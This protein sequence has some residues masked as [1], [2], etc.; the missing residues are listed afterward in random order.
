MRVYYEGLRK[1]WGCGV[2]LHICAKGYSRFMLSFATFG[3]IVPG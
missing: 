2:V 1:H 3:C